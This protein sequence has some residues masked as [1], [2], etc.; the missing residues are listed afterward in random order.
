VKDFIVLSISGGL[1]PI[2]KSLFSFCV[3]AV[4]SR[5]L[6]VLPK[7][8]EFL[9]IEEEPLI[10]NHSKSRQIVRNFGHISKVL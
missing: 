1:E 6:F 9:F 8:I 2:L 5:G 10:K 3:S 7:C 4:A